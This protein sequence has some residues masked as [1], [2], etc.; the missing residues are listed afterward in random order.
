M[1][2]YITATLLVILGFVIGSYLVIR[3]RRK[4]K[5]IKHYEKIRDKLTLREEVEEII[6][7]AKES[8]NYGNLLG[9]LIGGFI[10]I[11]VGVNLIP[12]I[13]DQIETAQGGNVTGAAGTI[14]N[15]T[16]I[17]FASGIMAVG[18]SLAIRGLRRRGL[19]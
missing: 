8:G 1:W 7:E 6:E 16:T 4:A 17:F 5:A 14:L 13:A 19:I 10:V 15:L 11:L 18:V 12:T 2:Y 3:G 9:T